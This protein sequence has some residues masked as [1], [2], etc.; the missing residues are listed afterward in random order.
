MRE[1]TVISKQELVQK[2]Q[3]K[4]TNQHTSGQQHGCEERDEEDEG[5][6]RRMKVVSLALR[7]RWRLKC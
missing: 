6:V 5:H 4:H 3:H 2:L 7:Q 1:K